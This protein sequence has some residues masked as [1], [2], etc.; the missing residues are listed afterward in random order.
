MEKTYKVQ[1]QEFRLLSNTLKVKQYGVKLIVKLQKLQ[2]ENLKDLDT[3]ELDRYE[4]RFADLEIARKQLD[5][6]FKSGDVSVEKQLK[7]LTEKVNQLQKDFEADKNAQL[8]KQVR[9][10]CYAYAFAELLWDVDFLKPVFAKMLTGGDVLKLNWNDDK[11]SEF[12]GEVI[13]DFFLITQ[14]K[15]SE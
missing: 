7:D 8:E 10:D 5:E 1:G 15:K 14:Q 12:I 13:N 3:F 4:K 11:I 9:Q 2:L 6:Q